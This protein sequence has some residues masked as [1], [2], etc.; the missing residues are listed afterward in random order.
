M[1]FWM[2][3]CLGAKTSIII[4]RLFDSTN[5]GI[6][7]MMK[8]IINLRRTILSCPEGICNYDE[9]L[10][11]SSMD[12]RS[13]NKKE[14]NCI[15]MMEL[16][17]ILWECLIPSEFIKSLFQEKLNIESFVLQKQQYRRRKNLLVCY[18]GI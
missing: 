9:I 7:T 5:V 14:R 6:V 16:K 13:L 10:D 4:C 11:N 8:A 18:R 15:L 17:K 2:T 1:N 12:F 3:F